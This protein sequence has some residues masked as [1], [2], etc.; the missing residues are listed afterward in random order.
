[1]LGTLGAV[2]IAYLVYKYLAPSGI[3]GGYDAFKCFLIMIK[4]IIKNY[5]E[6]ILLEFFGKFLLIGYSLGC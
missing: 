1:M 6:I 4:I 3:T 5:E 2:R